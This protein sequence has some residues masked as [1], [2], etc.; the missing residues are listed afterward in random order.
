MTLQV[1]HLKFRID[2]NIDFHE[3]LQLVSEITLFLP[4]PFGLL[5][6]TSTSASSSSSCWR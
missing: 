2:D 3:H 5:V 4:L 6:G 1:Y